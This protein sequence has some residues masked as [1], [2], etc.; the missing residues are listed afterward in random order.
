GS[1]AI[2]LM[3]NNEEL[4]GKVGAAALTTGERTWLLPL[5]D[6]YEELIESQ[7]ADMINT[8]TRKEAGTIVGG[9]FLKQFV[10]DTAWAH[11]DIASVM[12]TPKA[13]PYLSAGPS[14]KGT[15]LLLSLIESVEK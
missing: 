2:G 3:G 5:W 10:G 1:Q 12:W 11:L 15:R 7:V 9:M 4:L 14:A 8:S 6:E 13:G